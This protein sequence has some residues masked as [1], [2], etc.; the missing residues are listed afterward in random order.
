MK[1]F[2]ISLAILLLLVTTMTACK[3]TST[4]TNSTDTNDET[5]ISDE[6]N[7]ESDQKVTVVVWHMLEP[8]VI[9]TIESAY[10]KFKEENPNIEIK[11]ERQENFGEKLSLLST[12]DDTTVDVIAAPHDW[13]GKYA[14]M[15]VL[16]DINDKIDEKSLNNLLPSTLEAVKYKDKLY[17]V[18][19]TLETVTL[20]YNADI[21]KEAP[22]TTGELL[23]MAK[24]N[25]KDNQYGF[26]LPPN[27]AYFNS[28]FIY[29]N[30]GSYLDKDGNST[31][32]SSN[33]VETIK[34]LNEL[35]KYYPKDLDHGMVNDLFKQGK[36]AA[37]IAG[38]WSIADIKSSGINY[39]M[40]ILPKINNNDAKPF[41]TVQ[42]MLLS[43]TSQNKDAA[44]KVIEFYGS[45]AVGTALATSA[46]SIPA[47]K[48]VN[49][50]EAVKSNTDLMGY[51]NQ[52]EY[53]T[54]M[55]NIPQMGG[56]WDPI[57]QSLTSVVV[58]N[59]DPEKTLQKWQETA[60]QN[61]QNM[62]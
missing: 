6:Q 14:E 56:M 19:S 24:E 10:S 20:L 12:L 30:G 15:G 1:K 59:E 47:N 49:N 51:I 23:T 17:G 54:P 55:P 38:P 48:L 5:N 22:K 50:N 28:C 62:E 53:G 26:L 44:V 37:I 60:T 46:G 3:K 16:E 33:N 57:M 41:M 13:I 61:I 29:G 39:K 18:P 31:L 9:E 7:N 8:K 25:T 4:E 52:A 40:A 43:A 34:F 27:D 58:L 11:F 35:G 32:D 36:A 21:I 42:T 45:E 2:I